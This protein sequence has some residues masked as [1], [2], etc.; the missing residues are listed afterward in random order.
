MPK[1]KTTKIPA[2]VDFIWGSNVGAN[3]QGEISESFKFDLGNLMKMVELVT[4]V[5]R[6]EVRVVDLDKE[7]KVRLKLDAKTQKELA[8]QILGKRL[9]ILDEEWFEGEVS[10]K[11]K[12]LG[13]KVADF[14]NY[15]REKEI[16][17]KTEKVVWDKERA[18]DAAEPGDVKSVEEIK[19]IILKDP[20]GEK[21]SIEEV[22]QTMI[23]DVL[24]LKS[25][26]AKKELNARII[27]LSLMEGGDQFH[28]KLLKELYEN[29]EKLTKTKIQLKKSKGDGTVSNWLKD[30][31]HF[32]GIDEVVNTIKKT[33]YYVD[34]PNVKN[35]KDDQKKMLDGLLDLYINLKNFYEIAQK[36]D[37]SDIEIFSISEEEIEEYVK[38]VEQAAKKNQAQTNEGNQEPQLKEVDIQKLYIGDPEERNSIDL[39]KSKL[40][41]QTRNE[42]NKLA[43]Y[44]EEQ[45][46]RRRKIEIVSGIEL[47]AEIGALDNLLAKD[48]RY[49]E[50][51]IEYFKRNNLQDE[52]DN[53]K[54]DP[55]QAKYIEH[56][57][58][59]VFLER[60][61][62]KEDQGA[63]YA[64]NISRT[65]LENGSPQ[66]GQL[67]YLDLV[68][69]EFKWN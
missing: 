9:L 1:Q 38:Q 58:K 15:N 25:Y 31:I 5:F 35:L 19:P 66:Y 56:F 41:D 37:L 4:D 40:S 44:L 46:L 63:R 33:K 45:L 24:R 60:L 52:I 32:A 57:L 43:D 54:K 28:A 50:Y 6:K 14:E 65:L 67:A 17:L 22:F 18:E 26:A 61:G 39:A 51:L 34:S 53:Y 7:L 47:I 11:I 20:E 48:R 12:A 10:K 21:K 55:Y 16:E 2:N 23:G 30:Y 59:F 49:T 36:T 68:T 62:M 69:G 29:K 42:L 8:L 64:A 13:G 27:T 3:V